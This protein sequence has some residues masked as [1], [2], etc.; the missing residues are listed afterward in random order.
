MNKNEEEVEDLNEEELNFIKRMMTE[1]IEDDFRPHSIP[2]I[3]VGTFILW[4]CWLFFNGGSTYTIVETGGTLPEKV[5]MN[6][7]L[8]ASS[9]GLWSIYM[10]NRILGTHS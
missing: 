8:A 2:Y 7:I 5:M 4:V 1:D 9:G 3:V 10:K 6:T